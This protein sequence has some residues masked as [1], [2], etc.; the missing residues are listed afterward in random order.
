MHT[1]VFWGE[2]NKSKAEVLTAAQLQLHLF[3]PLLCCLLIGEKI[4]PQTN[5]IHR[6]T[7]MK[8]I[9]YNSA[10]T[11]FIKQYDHM[12]C[13]FLVICVHMFLPLCFFV[14]LC[15]HVRVCAFVHLNNT[16]KTKSNES[17]MSV[18]VR[19]HSLTE[20]ME[21]MPNMPERGQRMREKT[22]R[23]RKRKQGSS[24][25]EL[26]Y[27]TKFYKTLIVDSWS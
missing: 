2:S 5:T 16:T 9:P 7:H 22:E 15:M 26:Q 25:Q 21:E 11:S 24:N 8:F 12:L 1:S 10:W 27:L 4:T 18:W 14:Y 13:R 20:N 6:H 19:L 17:H 3:T 23:E